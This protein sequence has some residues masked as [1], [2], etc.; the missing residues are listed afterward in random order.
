VSVLPSKLI[1]PGL[2]E[3][4]MMVCGKKASNMAEDFLLIRIAKK[5]KGNGTWAKE[6]S[7][8][9]LKKLIGI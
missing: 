9:I 5:K 1:E 4:S 7:G 3:E 8:W 6:L 2:T